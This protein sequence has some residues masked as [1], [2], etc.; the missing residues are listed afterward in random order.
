M[1]VVNNHPYELWL[2]RGNPGV[3]LFTGKVSDPLSVI[4]QLFDQSME[5]TLG[6]KIEAKLG[7]QK[8]VLLIGKGQLYLLKDLKHSTLDLTSYQEITKKN[9]HVS[10]ALTPLV[11]AVSLV[12]FM[13]LRTTF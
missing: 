2:C 13:G 4:Q 6:E 8:Q 9:W 12:I 10:L 1:F 3:Y 7:G 5:K 11:Y